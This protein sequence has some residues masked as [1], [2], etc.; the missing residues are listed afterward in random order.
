MNSKTQRTLFGAG[1]MVTII[2]M[3]AI[4][5]FFYAYQVSVIWGL[6]AVEPQVAIRAMQGINAEVRNFWFAPSFFGSLVAPIAMLGMARLSRRRADAAILAGVALLYATSAFALTLWWNVPLNTS[7]AQVVIPADT[8][9]AA[10]VWQSFRD[11][12]MI[13]NSLRTV[14]AFV[15]LGLLLW[16]PM[17]HQGVG[18]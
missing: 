5:G 13:G 2:L 8:D 4:A 16:I 3:A 1:L 10:Q 11:A 17:R 14:A 12:W 18:D 6:D 15:A 9:A 7:L